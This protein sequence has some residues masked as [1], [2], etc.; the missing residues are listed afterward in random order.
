MP[1]RETRSSDGPGVELQGSND[2]AVR[3]DARF[4]EIMNRGGLYCGEGAVVV[5]P[6]PLP[7]L[8]ELRARTGFDVETERT[9]IVF[10]IGYQAADGVLG[11]LPGLDQHGRDAEPI[12]KIERRQFQFL[13]AR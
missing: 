5:E 12:G 7:A 8:D 4:V 9:A 2:A 6:H 1:R 3:I 10:K 13:T 11:L